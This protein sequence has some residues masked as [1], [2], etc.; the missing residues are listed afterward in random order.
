MPGI[1]V[2]VVPAPPPGVP[3]VPAVPVAPGIPGPDPVG[4]PVS[5][6]SPVHE[7]DSANVS[8][9]AAPHTFLIS[10]GLTLSSRPP[11]H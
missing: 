7:R 11:E 10:G 2:P 1:I 6:I 4:V 9:V 3:E 8:A 5:A